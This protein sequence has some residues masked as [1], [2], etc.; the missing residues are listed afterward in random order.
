M[1][2]DRKEDLQGIMIVNGIMK[3]NFLAYCQYEMIPSQIP[4]LM[5]RYSSN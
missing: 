5:T 3:T 1:I 4:S 2:R